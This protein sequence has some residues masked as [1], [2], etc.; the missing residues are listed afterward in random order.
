M[1][2]WDIDHYPNSAYAPLADDSIGV[3]RYTT[4][5]ASKISI[6]YSPEMGGTVTEASPF[7]GN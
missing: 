6:P 4:E 5:E 2:N 7:T 1:T 3:I